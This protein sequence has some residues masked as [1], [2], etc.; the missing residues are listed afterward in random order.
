LK[1][2]FKKKEAI[3]NE[4]NRR[5]SLYSGG[6]YWFRWSSGL[7]TLLRHKTMEKEKEAIDMLTFKMS[8]EIKGNRQVIEVRRDGL[9]VATIY[10]HD[11]S[12]TI[13]SKYLKDVNR[14]DKYPPLAE[15]T[16][17]LSERQRT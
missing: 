13:V 5:I 17:N 3:E 6:Y 16:F 10:P 14:I 12:V 9:L 1:N 11:K 7:S 15:V 2:L 4:E 8:K